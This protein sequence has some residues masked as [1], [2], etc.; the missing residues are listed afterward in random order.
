MTPKLRKRTLALMA[1][2]GTAAGSL[3]AATAAAAVTNS[4]TAARLVAGGGAMRA[5]GTS[6]FDD[7]LANSEQWLHDHFLAQPAPPPAAC[8]TCGMG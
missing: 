1:V 2:A 6:V 8:V 5:A 4:P 3:T 7:V